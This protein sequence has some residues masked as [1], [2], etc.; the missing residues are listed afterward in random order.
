MEKNHLFL[1]AVFFSFFD[2]FCTMS[3]TVGKK[4]KSKRG[5]YFY[6][7]NLSLKEWNDKMS[8]KKKKLDVLGTKF[9]ANQFLK[10][11]WIHI[12]KNTLVC[13]IEILFKKKLSKEVVILG[14][15]NPNPSKIR[16]LEKKLKHFN[17]LNC[18]PLHMPR[19]QIPFLTEVLI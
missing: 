16:C 12:L 7:I 18:S 11:Q 5:S 19:T 10:Y 6:S 14:C 9:C 8:G 2:S 13:K 4:L 3:A 15:T 17:N 1:L